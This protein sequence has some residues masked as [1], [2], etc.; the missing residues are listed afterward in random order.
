MGLRETA[1]QNGVILL[2]LLFAELSSGTG[3]PSTWANS[4]RQIMS[5]AKIFARG[6]ITFI[7]ISESNR[8]VD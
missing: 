4:N 7:W 2:G 1:L 8:T 5:T 6:I 3:E